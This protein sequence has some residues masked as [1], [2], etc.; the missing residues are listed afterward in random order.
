M[1]LEFKQ[2]KDFVHGS[3]VMEAGHKEW[4][5]ILENVHKL[6][7][8]HGVVGRRVAGH[9]E[10]DLNQD[11]GNFANLVCNSLN[12]FLQSMPNCKCMCRVIN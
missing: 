5:A 9:V 3:H 11:Q 12:L 2:D 10:K 1:D 4:P 6:N 8:E 7:G